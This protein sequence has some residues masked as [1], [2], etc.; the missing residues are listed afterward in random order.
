MGPQSKSFAIIR[1]AARAA[2]TAASVGCAVKATPPDQGAATPSTVEPGPPKDADFDACRAR[3]DAIAAQPKLPGAPR[4]DAMRAEILGRARGE[5]MVFVRAPEPSSDERLSEAARKAKASFDRGKPGGRTVTLQKQYKRDP[6]T[7]R[8]VLLRE[9]YAYA[10]DPIDALALIT[11]VHLADL[12]DEPAI[13]L[14]RGG[15]TRKLTR[16]ATR[17]EVTYRYTDGP[18]KDR[19]AELLFGDRVAVD[20]APLGAPLHRDLASLSEGAGFD[21]ARLVHVAERAILAELRFGDRWAKAVI[22]AD[23]AAL[24]LACLAEERAS[25]DAIQKALE[26][27]GPHRRGMKAVRAAVTEGV[28]DALRF[29]RPEG[30]KTAERDGHLRPVWLTA[31]L[32]GRQTFQVDDKSYPVFDTAGKAWPPEVCVDFVLDSFERASGTWYAPRG[33]KLGRVK[34][35]LDFDDDKIPNRRGVMAFGKF[36]EERPD[37]FEYRRFVGEE[38]IPFGERTKFFRYLV[39]HADLVRPGD[40]VAIHGKKK[41]NLIHQHAILIERT[42]PIT[43][44]PYG[45][46]DQMKK[47][48]RRTWEGIMAEAPLRSLYYRARPKDAIFSKVDP[49]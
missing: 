6:A 36:A 1:W 45:L 3:W 40:V 46:A 12:F 15:E 32:Q 42:D 37:L 13:E 33:D 21:R 7:L 31:Y 20:L 48:R 26:A 23:G 22:D 24:S 39:D 28:Q 25:R 19:A 41:D 11:E 4:F 10:D 16:V 9:G 14:Q 34:G 29:D 2:L 30:E 49:G 18:A 17:N 35:K 47:P 38:R 27:N 8:A 5:P 43:G 44:F